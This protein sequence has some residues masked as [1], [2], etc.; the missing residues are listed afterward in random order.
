LRTPTLQEK[1]LAITE[2]PAAADPKQVGQF[3]DSVAA[4]SFKLA[5]TLGTDAGNA[6]FKCWLWSRV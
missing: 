4:N 1:L 2:T 6:D 5:A 3:Q